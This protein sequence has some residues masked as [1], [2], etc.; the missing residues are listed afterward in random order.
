M[1]SCRTMSATF[2]RGYRRVLD[3]VFTAFPGR[4][5]LIPEWSPEDEISHTMPRTA[6]YL[7]QQREFLEQRNYDKG[8]QN[9]QELVTFLG[10]SAAR[11]EAR[12]ASTLRTAVEED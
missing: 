1:E 2:H 9:F 3:E 10:T 12:I 7:E 6:L 5:E 8:L 4:L 11:R